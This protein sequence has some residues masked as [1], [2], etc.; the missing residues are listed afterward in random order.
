[1]YKILLI[2]DEAAFAKTLM[3][4]LE[5]NFAVHLVTD[6]QNFLNHIEK[7]SPLHFDLILVDLRMPS[8]DGLSFL[9]HLRKSNMDLPPQALITSF[10]TE[11]SR[12]KA[13]ENR[14][15]DFI[16][17]TASP[18]EIRVRIKNAIEL[19]ERKKS[20]PSFGPLRYDPKSLGFKVLGEPLHLTKKEN[21]I[22]FFL[23]QS[24]SASLQRN[25]LIEKV[26]TQKQVVPQTLNTHIFNLNMKLAPHKIQVS[27]SHAGTAKLIEKANC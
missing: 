22:L 23:T 9:Q 5:D 27:V 6:P 8:M 18:R 3:M 13:Y 20:S 26:W 16:D 19:S 2:D 15:S 1:M 4:T 24:E 11:D 17:K 21:S 12:F 25:A 14:I 7:F 10:N